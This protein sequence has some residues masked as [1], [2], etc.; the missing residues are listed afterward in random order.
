MIHRA[1]G[2]ITYEAAALAPPFEAHNQLALALKI[3]TE[4][5][6]RLPKQFSSDL[7]KTV[8]WM[9]EKDMAKRPRIADL[10][11]LS[12]LRPAMLECGLIVRESQLQYTYAA[13]MKDVARREHELG[14]REAALAEREKRLA[15]REK[16]LSAAGDRAEREAR[17]KL[18]GDP[19]TAMPPPPPVARDPAGH[20]PTGA[21]GKYQ[22]K[23]S[24]VETS[25]HTNVYEVRGRAFLLA[26]FS[27][28][29]PV[30][31]LR[32]TK[33]IFSRSTDARRRS[34][35]AT[36]TRRSSTRRPRTATTARSQQRWW[37]DTNGRL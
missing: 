31:R 13:K 10:E 3:T 37:L 1:A 21:L 26:M 24:S 7:S 12:V 4:H 27:T 35:H 17:F 8:Q 34:G 18:H 15:D 20:P 36:V 30:P 5:V 22:K 9:L 11:A 2:C 29:R 6:Q 25:A 32:K 16:R 23:R 28:D 33:K 19:A 14:R